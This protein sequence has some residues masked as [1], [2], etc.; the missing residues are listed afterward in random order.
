MRGI[1][2]H[3]HRYSQVNGKMLENKDEKQT[4]W[5]WSLLGLPPGATRVRQHTRNHTHTHII[6]IITYHHTIVYSVDPKRKDVEGKCMKKIEQVQ[7]KSDAKGEKKAGSAWILINVTSHDN[8][9]F[10]TTLSALTFQLMCARLLFQLAWLIT[11]WLFAWKVSDHK[12]TLQHNTSVACYWL[13]HCLTHTQT[14][15]HTDPQTITTGTRSLKKRCIS[16]VRPSMVHTGYRGRNHR[17]HSE[18][19]RAPFAKHSASG[20]LRLDWLVASLI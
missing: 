16:P 8:L 5:K 2:W 18:E 15:T 14:Q 4:R 13:T 10:N 11:L 9:V 6:I 12:Q 17:N 7:M 20:P 3:R 1:I 19:E